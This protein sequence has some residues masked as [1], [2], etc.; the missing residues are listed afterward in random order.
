MKVFWSL[1]PEQLSNVP[2]QTVRTDWGLN[3]VPI[4]RNS[5][6]SSW[7]IY[8]ALPGVPKLRPGLVGAYFG[9]SHPPS[10]DDFMEQTAKE[11]Q[12]LE[13][14]TFSLKLRYV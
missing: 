14:N 2:G 7:V 6:L 13:K 5:S 3:K 12:D 11:F 4:F 1:D 9:P 8:G 10:A